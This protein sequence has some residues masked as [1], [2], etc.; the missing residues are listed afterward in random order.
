MTLFFSYNVW[1]PVWAFQR[2]RHINSLLQL[3]CHKQWIMASTDE[4]SEEMGIAVSMVWSM[5]SRDLLGVP[6]LEDRQ[7]QWLWWATQIPVFCLL[8]WSSWCPHLEMGVDD[9]YKEC[10]LIL[11]VHVSGRGKSNHQITQATQ[12]LTHYLDISE[13][14]WFSGSCIVHSSIKCDVRL[15]S[16][17]T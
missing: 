17:A 12:P 16:N 11:Y 14:K 2:S 15:I 3:Q 1:P 5:T 10:N 6:Q 4:M 9:G 7:A 8:D 13:R